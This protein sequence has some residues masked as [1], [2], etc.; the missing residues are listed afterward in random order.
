MSLSRTKSFAVR[1]CL[2]VILAVPAA[3]SPVSSFFLNPDATCTL[4]QATGSCSV[5]QVASTGGNAAGNWLGLSSDGPIVPLAGASEFGIRVEDGVASGNVLQNEIIPVSWDFFINPING[6]PAETL[7]W[8]F[9]FDLFGQQ[10]GEFMSFNS[11]TSHY[12]SEVRGS[13]TLTLDSNDILTGYN[14]FF[15]ADGEDDRFSIT[16]PGSATL[17]INSAPPISTPEPSDALLA[18]SGVFAS[19]FLRRQKRRCP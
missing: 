12:G 8:S 13:A 14:I 17:D 19:L 5:T 4:D 7:D 18:A 11:G 3:A 16:I 15:T 9:E 10:S 2:F 6:A 1:G